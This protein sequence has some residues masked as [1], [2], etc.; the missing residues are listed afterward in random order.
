MKTLQA[1]VYQDPETRRWI[2]TIHEVSE[3]WKT[4]RETQIFG[5]HLEALMY[6]KSFFDEER[7]FN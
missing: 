2:C 1:T 6:A 3:Q 5:T 7:E 4:V